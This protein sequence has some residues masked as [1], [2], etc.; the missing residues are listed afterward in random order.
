MAFKNTFYGIKMLNYNDNKIDINNYFEKYKTLT[1][2]T[3]YIT[4]L[5]FYYYFY[6]IFIDIIYNKNKKNILNNYNLWDFTNLNKKKKFIYY[7]NNINNI[8]NDN[9]VNIVNEVK[10]NLNDYLNIIEYTNNNKN[11]LISY[12]IKINKIIKINLIDFIFECLIYKGILTKININNLYNKEHLKQDKNLRINILKNNI[13]SDYD[14][15]YYYINNIQF[16]NIIINNTSYLN[17]II[18]NDIWPV[19]FAFDW[20]SQIN[21]YHHFINNRIMLITAGTG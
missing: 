3:I 10:D 8:L 16:K 14:N 20:I 19:L 21:F 17:N 1:N 2:N 4:F 5:D 18:N 15:Y 11:L 6:Y 13:T 12:F 7:L 9:E